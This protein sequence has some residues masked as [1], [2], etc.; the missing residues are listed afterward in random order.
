MIRV[1]KLEGE[2]LPYTFIVAIGEEE[3]K[4]TIN[5]Y[6]EKAVIH[7][8]CRPHSEEYEYKIINR[9]EYNEEIEEQLELLE[10]FDVLEVYGNPETNYADMQLAF[11]M[12]WNNK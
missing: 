6:P 4:L 12:I 11:E 2:I 8:L 10:A 1:L 9:R 5:R 7:F 3:N